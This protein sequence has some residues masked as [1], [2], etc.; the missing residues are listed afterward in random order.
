MPPGRGEP[1]PS[2]ITGTRPF[3]RASGQTQS[4]GNLR[5]ARAEPFDALSR[6]R[7]IAYASAPPPTIHGSARMSCCLVR[8]AA[9]DQ[10]QADQPR[11]DEDRRAE[12]R[13]QAFTCR[14]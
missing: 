8:T 3:Q 10:E 11:T 6:E 12:P 9:R 2:V 14:V 1:N 13:E 4:P 5:G 7:A